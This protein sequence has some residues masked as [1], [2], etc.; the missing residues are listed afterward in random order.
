MAK[1]YWVLLGISAAILMMM[2]RDF[3]AGHR[4]P[5]GQPQLLAITPQS[6]PQFAEE[7]NRSANVKRVVLLLSPT[8]PVCLEGSSKINAILQR[9]PESDVRVFAVWGPMLPTDWSQPN[10]HALARLSDPR[11]VQVWDTKHLI[12]GLVEKGAAGRRPKCCTRNGSWW[13]LIAS[14]PPAAK[15]TDSAPPPIILNGTIVRTAPE[16]EAELR[17]HS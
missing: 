2:I 12:A 1:K 8:C 13:D 10:T 9:N 5:P 7:F 16:L 4:T 6:L 3:S 11:V 14:Y 17:Q 15:W